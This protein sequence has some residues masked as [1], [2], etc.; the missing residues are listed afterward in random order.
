MSKTD[1]I[2]P[3]T[4]YI[5]ILFYLLN[6]LIFN[7]LAY[8]LVPTNYNMLLTFFMTKCKHFLRYLILLNTHFKWLTF[9]DLIIFIRNMVNYSTLKW[10]NN[11]VQYSLMRFSWTNINILETKLPYAIH[12]KCNACF[13]VRILYMIHINSPIKHNFFKTVMFLLFL[14]GT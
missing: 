14:I 7:V 2:V 1:I 9:C 10:N 3:G 13:L 12:S 6:E 11:Y 8:S 5:R 4:Y